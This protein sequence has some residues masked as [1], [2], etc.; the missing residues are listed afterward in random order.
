MRGWS[1]GRFYI[2]DRGE[3]GDV[4]DFICLTGERLVMQDMLYAWQERGD[5]GGSIYL[6]RERFDAGEF[7]MLDERFVMREVLQ[8]DMGKF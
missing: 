4:R 3:V 5:A 7:Y 2:L 6:T 1:C 8:L